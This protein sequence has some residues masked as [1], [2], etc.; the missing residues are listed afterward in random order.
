MSPQPPPSAWI[1]PPAPFAGRIELVEYDPEWPRQYE[2]VAARIRS[3]LGNR[4]IV[5]EHAGSTSVPG[6]AAKPVI[7]IDVVV[8]SAEDVPVT[9]ERLRKLGYVYQGEKGIPGRAAFMRPPHTPRHHLYVVVAGSKPHADHVQFRDFLRHHPEVMREYA[10]LKRALASDHGGDRAGYT[11]AKAAF[12]ERV[13][14]A[15]RTPSPG[16]NRS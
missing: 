16:T 1:V 9:I 10:D 12:I 13:L 3:A 2:A 15:A 4:A 7:D 14:A 8:R 11:E 5:L 6:L